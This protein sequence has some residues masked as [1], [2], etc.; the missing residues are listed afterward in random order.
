M[1]FFN[2][3]FQSLITFWDATLVK[4]NIT[5]SLWDS[6]LECYIFKLSNFNQDALNNNLGI[7]S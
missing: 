3:H 2:Q 5:I 1:L 7:K 4:V 6:T